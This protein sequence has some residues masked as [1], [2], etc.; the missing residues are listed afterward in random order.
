[1]S[2][3][4]QKNKGGRPPVHA[5]PITVRVPPEILSA[6]D[7]FIDEQ[8]DDPSRPEAIRRIMLDYFQTK[9]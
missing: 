7:G 5:T 4:S 6:L 2:E 1:M 9:D 3:T 8:S